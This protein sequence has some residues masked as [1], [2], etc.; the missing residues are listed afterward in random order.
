MLS[1]TQIEVEAA[2][3][4]YHSPEEKHTTYPIETWNY[5]IT[6]TASAPAVEADVKEEDLGH[7]KRGYTISF[8]GR[9]T[10]NLLDEV[11]AYATIA[12]ELGATYEH[13]II[14]VHDWMTIPAGIDRHTLITEGRQLGNQ[15]LV[16]I[17]FEGT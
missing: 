2:L 4:P 12:T 16:N 8:S 17:R 13:D 14:H 11:S 7:Q 5:H 9:Y 3:M 6:P 1:Y 10:D 15:P